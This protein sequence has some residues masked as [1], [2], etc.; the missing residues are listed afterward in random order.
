MTDKFTEDECVEAVRRLYRDA[1]PYRGGG[2][3]AC[4]EWMADAMICL[5]TLLA[6]RSRCTTPVHIVKDDR[7]D[8]AIN[9]LEQVKMQAPFD[10]TGQRL[11]AVINERIAALRGGA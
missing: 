3:Q 1:V 4:D 10:D 11:R 6:I 9:E 7:V 5:R 2:T 8:F